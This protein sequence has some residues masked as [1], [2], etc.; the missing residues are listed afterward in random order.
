MELCEDDSSCFHNADEG[1]HG[2]VVFL[3]FFFGNIEGVEDAVAFGDSED[4]FGEFMD[5]LRLDDSSN[6]DQF[7][8]FK[9]MLIQLRIHLISAGMED[10]SGLEK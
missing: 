2:S 8:L 10:L 5:V 4:H 7:E 1:C 3:V 9:T 6:I